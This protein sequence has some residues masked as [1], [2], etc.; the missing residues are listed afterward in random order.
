MFNSLKYDAFSTSE[1]E[2]EIKYQIVCCI[3]IVND[4]VWIET[5][6]DDVLEYVEDVFNASCFSLINFLLFSLSELTQEW[7]IFI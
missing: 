7:D 1:A 2:N 5:S 3:I 4:F 6:A